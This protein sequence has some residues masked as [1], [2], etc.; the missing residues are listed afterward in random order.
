MKRSEFDRRRRQNL[1][2]GLVLGLLA[3]IV[4]VTILAPWISPYDPVQID[5]KNRLAPPSTA[6]WLG[7]DAL[8]RDVFSRVLHGGRASLLLA[9]LATSFSMALG[10]IIG[11]AAG[12]C[13]GVVD[14]V[15]TAVANIFQGLPGTMMMIA[16]VGI[17]GSNTRSI[18]LALV[19]TSWVGFSRLVRGDV[20]RVKNEL[21]VEGVR[22]LGAGNL[23]IILR[24]VLPNIRTNVIITFTT[25]VGRVVLSVAGLSY[26][27]L[28]IQPP[29]P[30]WGEMI[31]GSA[32]RYFRSAPHLLWA[33]G[34][35]IIL[36]TLSINLLGDLLRDRMDVKQDSVKE[37]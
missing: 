7:T 15:I 20:M 16:L 9:V 13:G 32:R 21:F 25:R 8:G 29:T 37:L 1:K 4:L 3:V 5:M 23:R 27:G 33:P 17:L 12:Y 24:H 22:S 34:I 30:D 14:T 26:L 6:H 36:L 31:S 11:V 19:F 35:C 18:I 10:L 2:L 28:G